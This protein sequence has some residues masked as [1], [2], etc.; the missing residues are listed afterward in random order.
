METEKSNRRLNLILA[1][2]FA[3]IILFVV[4][5]IMGGSGG[6]LGQR[7]DSNT[8]TYLVTLKCSECAEIGMQINLWT[9]PSRAGVAG[10][11]PH[12]TSATVLDTDSY[13]GVLHYKV[14]ANGITG[15]VSEGFVNR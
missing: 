3:C 7:T 12:N 9:T 15:W 4:V 13:N 6:N 5:Q 2:V 1:I 10:S 14:R 8:D 11:V